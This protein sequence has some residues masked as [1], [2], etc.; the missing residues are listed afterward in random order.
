M[1]IRKLWNK[2]IL[3]QS[4]ELIRVYKEKLIELSMYEHAK[5]CTENGNGATGGKSLEETKKH[6]SERFLT[7]S[8]RVQFVVINPRGDFGYVSRDL[9][10]TF[11]SGNISILD[12]PGGT[13]A[14]ILSLL[15]NIAELR[16]SSSLP[17]LPLYINILGGDYSDSALAIYKELLNEV[18][19][20]LED[21]LIYV[22][23]Q[24]CRW[25]ASDLPSTNILLNDWL[26]KEEGNEEF[27]ILISAFSGVG[28]TIYKKFTKSFDFIQ[29]RISHLP[30][31]IVFIEPTTNEGGIFLKYINKIIDKIEIFLQFKEESTKQNRFTWHDPI[32]NNN[33]KS[34]VTIKLYGRGK[35]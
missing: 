14:S 25:D 33:A 2:D 21:Q 12:I 24:T 16:L 26:K 23:Y 8:A 18:K 34:G 6:F 29:T 1:I 7:S 15:C 22:K 5:N 32:R 35:A 10:S 3:Y 28:S 13:G 4:E 9:Q 20:Y 11:G 17:R 19:V 31:T 30:A 27:Y